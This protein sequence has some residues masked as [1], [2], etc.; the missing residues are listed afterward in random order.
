MA[1]YEQKTSLKPVKA[2]NITAITSSTT[3]VGSS[4]DT[5]G[6]E[7][8][9]LFVELGARTDGTFL[10]LVQDSDDDI[11]FAN[12]DDQ[13]LIGTEAEAQINTANTIKTIGYVGKKRYVKLSI[14]STAVTSGGAT[15]SATG[16]L[17]NANVKP[18]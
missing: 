11:N 14:V 8:L 6:F 13:F 10:P 17:A 5:K 4:I 15:V 12:V 7:S 1:S 3:T 9:T 16:I 2:L 18:V